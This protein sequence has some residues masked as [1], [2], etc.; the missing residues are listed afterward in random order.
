MKPLQLDARLLQMNASREKSSAPNAG[1]L[2]WQKDYAD[3]ILRTSGKVATF[4]AASP[5]WWV[6]KIDG[7]VVRS[8]KQRGEVITMTGNLKI[9]LAHDAPAR[10]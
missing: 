5:G 8:K 9:R 2:S 7:E 10:A 3:E 1:S 6:L 4:E